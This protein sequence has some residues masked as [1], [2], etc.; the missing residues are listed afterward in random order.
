VLDIEEIYEKH[1]DAILNFVVKRI[2]NIA[3][4]EDITAGVFMKVVEKLH[5]YNP[6]KACMQT[7]LFSIASHELVNYY[8]KKKPETSLEDYEY[9]L[10][11]QDVLEEI[12]EKQLELDHDNALHTMHEKLDHVVSAE[13]KNLLMLFYFEERSYADI[14]Y[15]TGIKEV[16]LRSKIHR[17]IKKLKESYPMEAMYETM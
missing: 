9:L 10:K 13:E 7:W 6:A 16:T 5:T 1:F 12:C 3:L 11:S 17:A 14:A 15:I 4:A 8:R 2:R